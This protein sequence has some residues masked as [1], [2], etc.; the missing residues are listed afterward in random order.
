MGIFTLFTQRN[1]TNVTTKGNFLLCI[2]SFLSIENADKC[3]SSEN[4]FLIEMAFIYPGDVIPPSA[5]LVF[6]IH[7]IDFHNPNDSVDIQTTYRPK[8]CNET[9]EVNDLV[10]YHYNC[11]LVDSTLLFS[12]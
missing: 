2:L 12:S 3:R 8:L 7:I 1:L 11:T 10:R 9:T 6:D 4:P 5:V